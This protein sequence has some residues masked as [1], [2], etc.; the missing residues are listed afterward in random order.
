MDKAFDVIVVGSGAGGLAAAA[1]AALLGARVV[2]LEKAGQI[3]GTTAT[4]GGEIWIPRSSQAIAAGIVDDADAVIVRG[5]AEK[6][7]A[8]GHSR[9]GR[10]ATSKL[11]GASP[12]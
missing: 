3:G 8:H 11:S 9:A 5:R 7:R 4:S 10:G 1:T 2:V 12:C 6:I